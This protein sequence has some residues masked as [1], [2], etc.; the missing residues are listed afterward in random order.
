MR[1]IVDQGHERSISHLHKAALADRIIRECSMIGWADGVIFNVNVLGWP[2]LLHAHGRPH[3]R[4]VKTTGF[5]DPKIHSSK[6]AAGKQA[7]KAQVR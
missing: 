2:L 4:T 5:S 7:S 6:Q 3:H 1:T